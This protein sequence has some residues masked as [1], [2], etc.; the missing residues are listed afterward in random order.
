MFTF[1]ADYILRGLDFA[2][3][4]ILDG[5]KVTRPETKR[6]ADSGNATR[7]WPGERG[8]DDEKTKTEMQSDTRGQR[9]HIRWS[10]LCRQRNRGWRLNCQLS[11]AV[12]GW[13]ATDV[14]AYTVV[15]YTALVSECLVGE[16]RYQLAYNI[17]FFS[18]Q[19]E[20]LDF[21]WLDD[22]LPLLQFLMFMFCMVHLLVRISF[23]F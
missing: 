1:C 17:G 20:L 3:S 6:N 9:W 15:T 23:K 7:P 10:I 18:F 11:P 4:Y 14:R 16:A 13:L 2:R 21:C 8:P 22:A 19:T 5:P 12:A